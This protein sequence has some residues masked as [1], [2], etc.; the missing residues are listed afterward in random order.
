MATACADVAKPP[1]PQRKR[2]PEARKGLASPIAQ[3]APLDRHGY[4]ATKLVG[5]SVGSSPR[6]LVHVLP[7]P[8]ALGAR[9]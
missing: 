5:L 1:S 4:R 2:F 3:L 7:C 8:F 9:E 6:L